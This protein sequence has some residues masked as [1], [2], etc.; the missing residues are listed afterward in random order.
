MKVFLQPWE[1]FSSQSLP[2]PLIR[3]TLSFTLAS[4]GGDFSS[5]VLPKRFRGWGYANDSLSLIFDICSFILVDLQL[6][7]YV[8]LTLVYGFCFLV[9]PD[10][11]LEG[12]HLFLRN[13]TVWLSIINSSGR[14]ILD[15]SRP[16]TTKSWYFFSFLPRFFFFFFSQCTPLLHCFFSVCILFLINT[17]LDNQVSPV[18]RMGNDELGPPWLKPLLRAN[19]FIPCSIH[20]DSNKSECNL[21]CLDCMGHALCSYCLINHKDHRV[22]QVLIFIYILL[23]L[24]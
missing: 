16:I 8:W 24:F 6:S 4:F 3:N 2:L 19:Y 7:L 5:V 12:F 21:F 1:L 20:G 23:F 10:S 11:I 13:W 15:L 18:G 9:C 17:I 22:V 14:V